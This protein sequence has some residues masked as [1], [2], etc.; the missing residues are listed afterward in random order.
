MD[1]TLA[2]TAVNDEF[3]TRVMVG[4]ATRGTSFLDVYDWT[5]LKHNDGLIGIASRQGGDT[6]VT[7]SS[8]EAEELKDFFNK[9]PIALNWLS[10]NGKVLWANDR[11]LQVLG[12]SR[13]GYKGADIMKLNPHSADD[14]LEVFKQLGT[15]NAIRDV[16]VRFCTKTGKIQH[17]LIDSN[18]NYKLD[19]SFNHT[20]CF[21]RDVTGYI[22]RE[23]R[24][25]AA[26]TAAKNL[27]AGKE[28]FLSKLLHSAKKLAGLVA[29]VS[30]AL[31]FDD[32]YVVKPIP[33]ALNLSSVVREYR[34]VEGVRHE[35]VVEE[36][37][38]D[39]SLIVLADA[40]MLRT[41]LDKLAW[42]ANERSPAGA[43]IRLSV[44][45]KMMGSGET[46]GVKGDLDDGGTHSFEL[47][48]DVDSG[49][50]LDESRVENVFRRYWSGDAGAITNKS[51]EREDS[52]DSSAAPG[53]RKG[54][55]SMEEERALTNKLCDS[56]EAL[57]LRLNVAFN[58]VQCLDSIQRVHSD[59]SKMAFK[60]TVALKT[61]SLLEEEEPK[62]DDATAKH[63]PR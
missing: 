16:P 53:R 1:P 27:V 43:S 12:Y 6:T 30:K 59:S 62:R 60:F 33:A 9:A 17:L 61:S 18:V 54:N 4:K 20:R 14:V 58:Y 19:G 26:V 40:T 28:R 38:F 31:K 44:A 55:L 37:G 22:L 25:E 11:E 10:A 51:D 56:E 32:G 45:R 24:A 52:G 63:Y 50:E 29:S 23:S 41:V 7:T 15:G 21:I 48:V 8:E 39:T 49:Q 5:L 42:H 47:T 36:I 35:V 46:R 57:G 3:A 2:M 34:N 13:E